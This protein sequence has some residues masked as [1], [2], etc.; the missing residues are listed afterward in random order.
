[1][2]TTELYEAGGQFLLS[3]NDWEFQK[4]QVFVDGLPLIRDMYKNLKYSQIAR[5][6][7]IMLQ[8]F[9]LENTVFWRK[10]Y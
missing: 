8:N 3:A 1:M 4:T 9:I 6:L 5:E 7:S 10:L 2:T